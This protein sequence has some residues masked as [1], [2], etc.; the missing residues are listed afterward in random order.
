MEGRE[1]R[2]WRN[3]RHPTMST[4]FNLEIV[5]QGNQAYRGRHDKAVNSSLSNKRLRNGGMT[6]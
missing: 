1:G 6:R 4:I 5:L 2:V 3:T